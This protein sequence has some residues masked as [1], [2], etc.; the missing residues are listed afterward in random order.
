M[1]TSRKA[2]HEHTEQSTEPQ[3]PRF[4]PMHERDHF[5][6]SGGIPPHREKDRR[7]GDVQL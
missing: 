4:Y 7:P 6:A 1:S 2:D 5:W 3:K